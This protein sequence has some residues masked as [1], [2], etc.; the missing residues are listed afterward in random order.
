M[1]STPLVSL[2]FISLPKSCLC[3][4]SFG[5]SDCCCLRMHAVS[6]QLVLMA[7]AAGLATTYVVFYLLSRT[8]H[9]VNRTTPSLFPPSIAHC[10]SIRFYSIVED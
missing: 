4:A 5:L 6:S 1:V 10:S 7:F 9:Y 8:N 2:I 3:S